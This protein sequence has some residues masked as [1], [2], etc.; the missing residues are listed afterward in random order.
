[1]NIRKNLYTLS[2]TQLQAFKDALNAIKADG[3]YDDFIARHHHSMMTA[4]L[5]PGEVGGPTFRNVAHRGP[6]FLPCHRYFCRELELTLQS[7]NPLVTLP[8]W[9]WA[10]DAANP[11]AAALW[12]TNVA[13][14]IYVGGDG[15]GPGGV[16]T[17]GPF[18]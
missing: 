14:R 5:S 13:Q 10:A 4:T 18:V 15:T 6:A 8:Y 7:K 11:A 1:M 3:S 17:T 2:D 9:D 16:V 12:N